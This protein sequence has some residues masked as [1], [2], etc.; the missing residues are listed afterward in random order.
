[1]CLLR[2]YLLLVVATIRQQILPPFNYRAVEVGSPKMLALSLEQGAIT[3][4]ST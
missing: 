1:M 2:S 3:R 4:D